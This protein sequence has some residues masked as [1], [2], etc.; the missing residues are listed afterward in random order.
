MH[1]KTIVE[2]RERLGEVDGDGMIIL[3]CSLNI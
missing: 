3:K 1:Y 2:E